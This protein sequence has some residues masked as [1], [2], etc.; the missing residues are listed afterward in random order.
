MESA[1]RWSGYVCPD[2]RFVF[3]VPRDHDGKGIVCPSCRRLMKIPTAADAT[4]PLL[5]S[6]RRMAAEEP[7]A[8]DELRPLKKRRRSKKAA[9][10]ANHSWEQ[11]SNITRTRRGDTRQMRL[12][13][14]SGAGLFLLIVA[15]VVFSMKRS[16]KPVVGSTAAVVTPVVAAPTATTA[17]PLVGRSEASL[18]AVMEP[19]VRRFLEATTV[20]DLLPLVRNPAVAEARM[21]AF[22][23]E[24]KIE[25]AGLAQFNSAGSPAIRGQFVSVA[26]RTRGQEEKS[27]ACVETPQGIKIDWESWVAWAD[28][29]WEKFLTSKPL[30]G[31][32]F[33]VTVSAV[34]YYNFGFS[35]ESKW[36]SY[37]L[38]SPD[39]EIS[40]YGYV[41]KGSVLEQQIHLDADTRSLALM[42]S[43]KFP[44]GASSS[45]QVEI[46]RFVA[47]G[48][49]EEGD[50]P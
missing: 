15:G 10:A 6:L 45:S 44:A 1:R 37:R 11:S 30:V 36:R 41:E 8:E 26:V 9:A 4:P 7:V 19:L 32:V 13:L 34:D 50:A 14:A 42:L 40:I 29:S 43:L 21:R 49:V 16:D 27:L 2:C 24:G 38:I 28:I 39:G 25:P 5:A 31:H 23:P 17:P 3:R 46:E 35:D 22:Y 47:E 48:W 20:D 33:R 18:L 12:I